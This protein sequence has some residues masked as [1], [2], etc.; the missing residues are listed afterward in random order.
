MLAALIITIMIEPPADR[1]ASIRLF[2]L[3][4]IAAIILAALTYSAKKKVQIDAKKEEWMRQKIA[5]HGTKA[6][7]LTQRARQIMDSFY[8]GLRSLPKQLK[9]AD[10]FLSKAEEEF[11]EKAYAPFW[12]NIEHA[13]LGL[14]AFNA[15]LT[16]LETGAES[17]RRLLK[18]ELHNFPPLV[19]RSNEIP[20]PARETERLRQLVRM[21]QKNFEFATIWEH[22]K[23][24]RVI[25]E[26][27]RTLGEAVN[28]LG[29]T[30]D[31]SFSRVTRTINENSDRQR[32]EQ[33]RLRK[34]FEETVIKWEE[35][36]RLYGE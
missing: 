15:N 36:K 33:V 28:N 26:G 23:T 3:L 11:H 21:G 5:E 20:N 6:A 31:D 29:L 14:G 17:Y 34:V 12:D 8:G 18:G 30:I 24:Q 2:F 35:R 9:E 13:A 7:E 32:E 19:I 16:R 10:N 22:R 1:A 4:E 27:F 25:L